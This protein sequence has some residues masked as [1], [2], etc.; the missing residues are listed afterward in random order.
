M[1]GLLKPLFLPGVCTGVKAPT[2]G[3]VLKRG[4]VV[5]SQVLP[6]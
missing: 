4:P 1:S 6:W 3:A 5:M 2:V